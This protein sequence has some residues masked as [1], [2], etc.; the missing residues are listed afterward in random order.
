MCVCVCVR[1]MA[2][3]AFVKLNGVAPT[4]PGQW[5]SFLAFYAGGSVRGSKQGRELRGLESFDRNADIQAAMNAGFI[6]VAGPGPPD[7]KM[8]WF[9]FLRQTINVYHMALKGFC[10]C[11]SKGFGSAA[12][13]CSKATVARRVMVFVPAVLFAFRVLGRAKLCAAAAYQLGPGPRTRL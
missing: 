1:S 4:A 3:L 7:I 5:P 2:W 10:Y 8:N 6:L 9:A 11:Y 12:A 13:P